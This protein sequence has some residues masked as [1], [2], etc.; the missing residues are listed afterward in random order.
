M[1][2]VLLIEAC[3]FAD[4][5]V[6]GM[7]SFCKQMMRA[8]GNRLALVG[9]STGN[10]PVG[11]WIEK[12]FDGVTFRYF[13]IAKWEPLTKKPLVPFRLAAYL[14]FRRYRK[15]IYSIGIDNLYTQ[16]EEA[17]MVMSDMPWKSICFRFA[18]VENSLRMSRYRWSRLFSG[19]HERLLFSA[20]R[21]V[22]VILASAGNEAI[23]QMIQRSNGK[24][25][26]ERIIRFP[27]RV[28]TDIFQPQCKQQARLQLGIDND[29]ILVM[30]C[31]RLNIVKGWDFI[32]DSF[33]IFSSYFSKASMYFVGDGEDRKLLS[34]RIAK[35]KFAKSI[36]ITGF[37]SPHEVARYINAADIVVV[38]SHFEGWSVAMVEALAC[39]KPIVTTDVSGAREMIIEGKNG[40]IVENRH[41]KSF[42]EAMCR[43]LA[44]KEVEHISLTIANKYALKHLASDLGTL[45]KPLA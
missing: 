13:A 12:E 16:S 29:E 32:L 14:Q 22:N 15:A 3:N 26:V 27:T 42:S 10:T 45:W 17:I 18:G 25:A 31:G 7:L 23:N 4:F 34:N 21:P 38:G 43:T 39:G 28:D 19:I 35:S 33:E 44:L 1:P 11:R 24:L 30:T 20:L 2:D 6:G 41:P 5:P 36:K 40:F 8:F 9:I 37:L